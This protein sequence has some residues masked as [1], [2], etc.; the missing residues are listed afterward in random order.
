[1]ARWKMSS[2]LGLDASEFTTGTRP[3]LMAAA[4]S[5]GGVAGKAG[6]CSESRGESMAFLG[7]QELYANESNSDKGGIGIREAGTQ[8]LTQEMPRPVTDRPRICGNQPPLPLSSKPSPSH[9]LSGQ[10]AEEGMGAEER[11]SRPALR[12]G[13]QAE[14]E[15]GTI[16]KC[17]WTADRLRKGNFK[18]VARTVAP[19]ACALAACL[20]LEGSEVA[21]SEAEWTITFVYLADG[22]P[23]T[24]RMLCKVTQEVVGGRP[25]LPAIRVELWTSVA[26]GFR[27][28]RRDEWSD[29]AP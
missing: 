3:G 25:L 12:R 2:P 8:S 27:V 22:R 18:A 26:V 29:G 6:D 1:M 16:P 5:R 23:C 24:L 14:A 19:S 13:K 28:K 15:V 4:S 9:W 17:Q 11:V 20:K 10:Q 7:M 21:A